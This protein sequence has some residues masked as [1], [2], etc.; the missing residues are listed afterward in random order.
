MTQFRKSSLALSL[1]ALLVL[2]FVGI[3]LHAVFSSQDYASSQRITAQLGLSDLTLFT[4]A[5]YTRHPSM[6]D[7]HTAF[8]DHP[9]SFDHFPTGWLIPAPKRFGGHAALLPAEKGASSHDLV[10]E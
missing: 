4:E 6:A 3:V 8:Q 10:D 2:G 5:R 7:L 1:L 9:V